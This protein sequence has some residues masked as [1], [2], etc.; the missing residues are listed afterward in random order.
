[1][2]AAGGV[3]VAVDTLGGLATLGLDEGATT[4]DAGICEA[5]VAIVTGLLPGTELLIDEPVL[6]AVVVVVSQS[7]VTVET[8]VPGTL[9]VETG[10]DVVV[11][12]LAV[13][14]ADSSC[15]FLAMNRR[16]A[17]LA[18]AEKKV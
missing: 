12:V 15:L 4:E 9:A 5:G 11:S 10:V 16:K 18:V 1:M 13:L 2:D 14:C 17:G 6:T 3:L 8:D 7:V